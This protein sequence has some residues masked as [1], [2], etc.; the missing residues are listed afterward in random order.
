MLRLYKIM[1]IQ[2]DYEYRPFCSFREIFIFL[3]AKYCVCYNL[4]SNILLL[5]FYTIL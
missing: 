3:N 1:L 5:I 4:Y 2:E